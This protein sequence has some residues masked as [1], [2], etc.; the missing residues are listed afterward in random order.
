MPSGERRPQRG[1]RAAARPRRRRGQ[2]EQEGAQ[3]LQEV[4]L[5]LQ[6][7]RCRAGSKTAE[8]TVCARGGVHE[9]L[10]AVDLGDR[11]ATPPR[12]DAAPARDTNASRLCKEESRA[13]GTVQTFSLTTLTCKCTRPSKRANIGKRTNGSL[14]APRGAR[15]VQNAPAVLRGGIVRAQRL[16][17]TEAASVMGCSEMSRWPWDTV[18]ALPT[19][20]G[21]RFPILTAAQTPPGHSNS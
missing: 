21:H 11:Q 20:R 17:E 1:P 9:R 13:Q 10:I 12:C 14:H 2:Q 4:H 15:R 5:A 3:A 8:C 19:L 16:H 6:E 18:R 7:L